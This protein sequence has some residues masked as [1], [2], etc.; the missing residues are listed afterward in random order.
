L[1][2]LA[3]KSA[4]LFHTLGELADR[5]QLY[6]FKEINLENIETDYPKQKFILDKLRNFGNSKYCRD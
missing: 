2:D 6:E 4:N 1:R 3:F 5:L